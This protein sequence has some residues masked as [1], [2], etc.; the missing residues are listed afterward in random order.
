M[1]IP[2][3]CIHICA[4]MTWHACGGQRRDL[5]LVFLFHHV[6]INSGGQLPLPT[7]PSHLHYNIN[8]E[9]TLKW[10]E[11]KIAFVYQRQEMIL[12]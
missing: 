5:G 4:V 11:K 12:I 2:N 1:L 3:A 10:P 7:E 8:E 6:G 9:G